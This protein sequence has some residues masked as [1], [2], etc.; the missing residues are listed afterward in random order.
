MRHYLTHTTARTLLLGTAGVMV[1]TLLALS[2]GSAVARVS[3]VRPADA[4]LRQHFLRGHYGLRTGASRRGRR[5]RVL[6]SGR[7]ARMARGGVRASFPA[8]AGPSAIQDSCPPQA[9]GAVCGHVDVPL[10]RAD[11]AAALIPVAFELYPHTDS[12]PATSV[13]VVNFGGPGAS[14][15]SLRWVVPF[16]FGP[17]LAHHDV[18]LIDDRGRGRSDA[19]DCPDYQHDTGPLLDIVAECAAQLGPRAVDYPTA[20]I[21]ADDETVRAALGYDAVDFAGTSYGAIDAAA[22]ATRFPDHLR[23]VLLD[24]PVGEPALDPIASAAGRTQRDLAIIGVLCS[25]SSACGRSAADAV[26][27]VRWLAGRVR[28]SP[29]VGTGLDAD[30]APHDVTVDPSYLLVHILDN[31]PPAGGPFLTQAEIPAAADA[32]ARGD[33]VPPLRLAAESDF[34]I[35]GDSGDP[36]DFSQGAFSATG[37]LDA[38]WPW[39]PQASLPERQA[40]WAQAVHNTPEGLFAPFRAAEILFTPF[41]G[42]D[43]CLP[44]PHTGTRPPVRSGAQYPQVPTLVL[45]GELDALPFVPQTAALFP[46]AKLIKVVGAGHNT[47]AWGC[48]NA[49]AAQFLDALQ[50]TDSSCARTSPMNYPGVTAFPRVASQSPTATPEPGNR[51]SAADLRIT[52][53]AA[54]AVLDALKRSFLSSSGHGPGLRGGTFDTDYSSWTTTLMGARWTKDV[55]VSGTLHWDPNSGALDADLQLDGP[56]RHDGS[57]HLHGGWLIPGAARS[58]EIAGTLGNKHVEATAPS[59]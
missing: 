17:A 37:C 26:D 25:R 27:S 46:D 53:V 20:E 52:R 50:V 3:A 10:D 55:A 33:A 15:T 41:G 43:S 12:G 13:I 5:T 48:S 19:I 47:F 56:G 9:A 22:Y 11:P 18:L 21:A 54:D 8:S 32:L 4:L 58:I 59:S 38:P 35:P 2:P 30:G 36:T 6:A 31:T 45:Q 51:A 23:S 7:R 14:T 24:A 42:A 57:V 40:Q 29:V 1:G 39:S 28:R 16:W 44:W 49:L 34:P